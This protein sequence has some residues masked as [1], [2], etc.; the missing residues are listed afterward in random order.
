NAGRGKRKEKKRKEE[1]IWLG[2]P[3][4]PTSSLFLHLKENQRRMVKE[5]REKEERGNDLVGNTQQTDFL[6]ISAFKGE[7][8][9]DSERGKR[10]RGKRK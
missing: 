8:T 10:K 2:V 5:E 6:F 7:S 4:K 3:N 9:P 1:M